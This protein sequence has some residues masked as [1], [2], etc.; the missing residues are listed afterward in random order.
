MI[1]LGTSL[2]TSGS[3]TWAR[4]SSS[5]ERIDVQIGR[6]QIKGLVDTFGERPVGEVIA[7]L[8]STGN[9]IVSVVNGNAAE[10]L[11]AKVG[12]EL[13]AVWPA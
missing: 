12:D 9:L 13:E 4:R 1:T 3:R 8:G 5:K 10:L 2:P 6:T 7:L 11:G